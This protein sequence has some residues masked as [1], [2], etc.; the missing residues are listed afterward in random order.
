[1]RSIRSRAIIIY[2]DVDNFKSVNDVKGHLYGDKCLNAVGHTLKSVYSRYGRCYRV[3]GDEFCVIMTRQLNSVE[4]LN[5]RFSKH[6]DNERALDAD[7]PNVSYGFAA[8]Y[9]K[10]MDMADAITNADKMMYSIKKAHKQ[11]AGCS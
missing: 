10:A 8:F 6:I 11:G 3:G 5:R 9:P 2:F 7:L 1:M 4:E